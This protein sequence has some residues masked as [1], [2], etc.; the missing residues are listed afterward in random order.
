M[1]GKI[2]AVKIYI[3][4]W[5]HKDGAGLVIHSILSGIWGWEI[6]ENS[7]FRLD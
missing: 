3:E 6:K 1:L 7:T 2:G 4:Y 5:T